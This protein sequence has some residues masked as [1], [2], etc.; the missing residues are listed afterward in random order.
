MYND[1]FYDDLIDYINENILSKLNNNI[2]NNQSGGTF[3]EKID[4]TFKELQRLNPVEKIVNF[5]SAIMKKTLNIFGIGP[6]SYPGVYNFL[7]Q[8][9]YIPFHTYFSN[10]YVLF[11]I[12]FIMLLY[13]IKQNK[14]FFKT[15]LN[16]NENDINIDEIIDSTI[17]FLYIIIIIIIFIE[18]VKPGITENIENFVNQKLNAV[19]VSIKHSLK[20]MFNNSKSLFKYFFSKKENIANYQN[21]KTIEDKSKNNNKKNLEFTFYHIEQKENNF[22]LGNL[23]TDMAGGSIIDFENIKK[24]TVQFLVDYTSGLELDKLLNDL[25]NSFNIKLKPEVK[26]TNLTNNNYNYIF[27]KIS[28]IIKCF[29]NTDRILYLTPIENKLESIKLISKNCEIKYYD[30]NNFEINSIS[31]ILGKPVHTALV[32]AYIYSTKVKHPINNYRFS[33]NPNGEVNIYD[34]RT[35][36]ELASATLYIK[37]DPQDIAILKETCNQVFGNKHSDSI[38]NNYFYSIL[39]RSAISLFKTLDTSIREKYNIQDLLESANP[40]IQYEILKTLKF[41][42]YSNGKI[43]TIDEWIRTLNKSQSEEYKNYLINNNQV[44]NIIEKIINNYNKFI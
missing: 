28:G 27:D 41:K 29:G 14:E 1:I 3:T 24:K 30:N 10:K 7:K 13:Y 26:S 31:L 6:A 44:K 18:F 21:K 37:K 19:K 25:Y 5:N 32:I 43:C 39:G 20:K 42:K 33:L 34:T 38:C 9:I 17:Q 22:D 8:Y 12:M 40:A 2:T 16:Q 11:N 36:N 15:I 35:G 23:F 4:Q